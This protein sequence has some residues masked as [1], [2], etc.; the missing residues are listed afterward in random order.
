MPGVLGVPGV[1][2]YVYMY[3]YVFVYGELGELSVPGVLVVPSAPG[4]PACVYVCVYV[5]DWFSL[6][7]LIAY[8]LSRISDVLCV[9]FYVS[10]LYSNSFV[11]F[12]F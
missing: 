9:M 5:Y 12:S 3:V 2:L 4:V 8:L 7:F 6:L 1:P 11:S 10:F